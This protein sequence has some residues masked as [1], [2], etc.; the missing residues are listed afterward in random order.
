LRLER[1]QALEDR[2]LQVHG[3]AFRKGFTATLE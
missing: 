1:G 2:G 3:S